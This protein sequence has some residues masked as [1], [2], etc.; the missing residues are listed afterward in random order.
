MQLYFTAN[1]C[2]YFATMFIT[3][4]RKK[5]QILIPTLLFLV[6]SFL[7]FACTNTSIK[8]KSAGA[9]SIDSSLKKLQVSAYS[10]PDSAAVVCNTI[11]TKARSIQYT[12]G[13]AKCWLMLTSI[14]SLKGNYDSAIAMANKALALVDTL[15]QF[16]LTAEILNEKGICYDY[17]SDYKRA[18]DNYNKSLHAFV[19][20]KDSVG[21]VRVK[22][23][24]GL[25]Y[26]NTGDLKLARSYFEECLTISKE[27]KYYDQESMALSNLGA[28]E[29]LLGEHALALSH[30]KQVL[31]R[32]L[33]TGN[34]TYIAYSYNNVADAYKQ[35]H[36]FD[37][38]ELYFKKSIQLK[39]KLEA[40]V[41]A[42]NSYKEYAD[43]LA[44][45][46]RLQDAETYLN[47][48]FAIAIAS[49]TKDYLQ[50][51]FALRSK[52]AAKKG[53]YKTAFAAL[54]SSERIVDTLAS[55]KLKTELI[56][57]EKDYA[58]NLQAIELQKFKEQTEEAKA[59]SITFIIASILFGS[60]ALLLGLMFRRQ[61]SMNRIQ[62]LQQQKLENYNQLLTEQKK[63][64][65]DGLE[66]KNKFL[67]FMAHEIRNPLGGIIGLTDLL[68]ETNPTN[69][70]REYLNY[71]KKASTH[72]LN[73]LNEV[74]D[75]QKIV[76]GNVE[77]SHIKFDLQDI[78]QQVHHL[79]SAN[80]R[81]KNILYHLN[82]DNHIPQVLIGDPVRLNQI[83]SNLINNAIKFTPRNGMIK[84]N[85]TVR[86]QTSQLV[87][88]YFAIIDTGVGIEQED[89]QKIFELYQQSKSGKNTAGTGLGLGIVKNLLELM[90]SKIMLSS[91]LDKGSTFSFEIIFELP[92]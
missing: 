25:I 21:Y 31:E 74:L 50:Q 14:Q 54:D 35:L 60:L 63:Q 78:F 46:G 28:V 2:N 44:E 79:Y 18:L 38:A 5:S 49:G 56:A 70:Q 85:A 1:T 47:K 15:K 13:E 61:K 37:S 73:L 48:A 89:Q 92:E 9:V 58:L 3:R 53:D 84:V 32:D 57:K 88:V 81:E 69:D 86:E 24:I 4:K 83:I 29:D 39:E 7:L 20:A 72:L 65:E 34:E 59:E 10:N 52:I 23:N 30:F 68:M 45:Q 66:M 51:C 87:K 41:A 43:M 19:L 76:S 17:K 91:E 22:N 64:I 11:L 42:L 77:I 55:T 82:Y 33:L 75:Y 80:I 26:Q 27:K 62:R 16:A 6:L 90:N 40:Q 12:D 71:Q 36:Q 67:S 8:A